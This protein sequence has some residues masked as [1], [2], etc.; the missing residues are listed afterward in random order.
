MSSGSSCVFLEHIFR[1]IFGHIILDRDQHH[2]PAG[3]HFILSKCLQKLQIEVPIQS[4]Y[5]FIISTSGKFAIKEHIDYF[6]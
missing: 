2:I 3:L 4:T 6:L 1:H 5:R